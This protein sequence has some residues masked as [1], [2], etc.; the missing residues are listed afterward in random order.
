MG[1]ARESKK[2]LEIW[3][4][5]AGISYEGRRSIVERY[6]RDGSSLTLTHE[7][8]N[9]ED[10]NAMAVSVLHRGVFG[11]RAHKIG[12]LPR[13]ESPGVIRQL[14]RGWTFEAWVYHVKVTENG[15]MYVKI[16]VLLKAPG[17]ERQA[18]QAK[19]TPPTAPEPDT[20]PL[21]RFK[22]R[23]RIVLPE[24]R[25][26]GAVL[27]ASALLIQG[28]VMISLGLAVG[29]AF[30]RHSDILDLGVVAAAIGTG[31]WALALVAKV[32]AAGDVAAED[33]VGSGAPPQLPQTGIGV[34]GSR[35]TD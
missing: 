6:C 27:I 24:A 11:T 32:P 2:E 31:I 25:L 35:P 3:T 13:E 16:N 5:V 14:E 20:K 26:Q 30:R 28:V 1:I 29:V 10:R 12:Y 8:G 15:W 19:P 33:Q 18:I 21:R 4:E 7:P 23:L 22:P 34:K 17:E 9:P